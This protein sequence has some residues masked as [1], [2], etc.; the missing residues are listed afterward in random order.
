MA[1]LSEAFAALIHEGTEAE[2]D[3]QITATHTTDADLSELED[4][5]Y[6]N[7]QQLG[8]VATGYLGDVC[9]ELFRALEKHGR[10]TSF[11][12]GYA[13]LKEEV[14]ELWAEIK[15]KVQDKDAIEKEAIQVAA[16]AIRLVLDQRN[17]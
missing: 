17:I 2:G 3:V 15:N 8:E 13:V 5:G 12:E 11:H 14:D 7:P 6:F 16:M 10:Q 9:T 1:T 4:S